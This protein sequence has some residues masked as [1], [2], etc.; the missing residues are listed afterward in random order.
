MFLQNAFRKYRTMNA[1]MSS[2]LI[3]SR[4]W[5]N[6]WGFKFS[7]SG[8]WR[9]VSIAPCNIAKVTNRTKRL[10][11]F[12]E[13]RIEEAMKFA[14]PT[15]IYRIWIMAFYSPKSVCESRTGIEFICVSCVLIKLLFEMYF[16]KLSFITDILKTIV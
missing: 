6:W 1:D 3:S 5:S 16:V 13:R 15:S 12:V 7:P 2:T 9:A 10:I 14:P 4:V 11:L 8:I